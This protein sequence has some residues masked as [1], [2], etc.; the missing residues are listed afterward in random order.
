MLVSAI[1]IAVALIAIALVHPVLALAV[2]ALLVYL[3]RVS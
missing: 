2:G 1:P 3:W